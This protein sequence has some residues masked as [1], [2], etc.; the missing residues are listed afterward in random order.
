MLLKLRPERGQRERLQTSSTFYPSRLYP[1]SRHVKSE[2]KSSDYFRQYL[3]FLAKTKNVQLFK[4]AH[5][6]RFL[7]F[8][9][10]IKQS[11]HLFQY[12][13]SDAEKYNYVAWFM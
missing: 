1:S 7:K 2:K 8:D 4:H 6:L 3:N 5:F 10:F 12:H 11:I 13:Q 9:I